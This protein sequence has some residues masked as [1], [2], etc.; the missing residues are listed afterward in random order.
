M[1][2]LENLENIG[3]MLEKYE[4]LHEVGLLTEVSADDIS[5]LD[6]SLADLDKQVDSLQG[7][8]DVYI[9]IF[10]GLGGDQ[11]G[12]NTEAKAAAN[13]CSDTL[14][15]VRDQL[16]P[17]SCRGNSRLGRLPFLRR[18]VMGEGLQGLDSPREIAC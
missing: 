15:K 2:I 5:G 10:D 7:S 16:D 4:R 3:R 14:T 17:G 12:N 13:K 9:K 8:L 18:K 6:S 1:Q 11:G